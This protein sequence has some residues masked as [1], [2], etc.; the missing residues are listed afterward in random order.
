MK[1]SNLS[2]SLLKLTTRKYDEITVSKVV[3][4]RQKGYTYRQISRGTGVSINTIS[5]MLRNGRRQEK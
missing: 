5:G 3:G 2:V 4:L 1:R